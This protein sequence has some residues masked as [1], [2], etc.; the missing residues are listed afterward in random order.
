MDA[1]SQ[2][3]H[4]P[5]FNVWWGAGGDTNVTYVEVVSIATGYLANLNRHLQ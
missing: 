4:G 3:R 5:I 2:G 1:P